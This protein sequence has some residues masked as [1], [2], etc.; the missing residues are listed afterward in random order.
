MLR[1]RKRYSGASKLDVIAPQNGSVKREQLHGWWMAIV[2]NR[3]FRPFPSLLP[4]FIFIYTG[5]RFYAVSFL[6]LFLFS[7]LSIILA[8]I[9]TVETAIGNQLFNHNFFFISNETGLKFFANSPFFL[10]FVNGWN[11][12]SIPVLRKGKIIERLYIRRNEEWKF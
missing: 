2:S 9:R 3:F 11:E 6:S 5:L 4:L 8:C 7:L 1:A 10:W 12:N